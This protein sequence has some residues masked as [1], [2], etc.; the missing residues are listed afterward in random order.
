MHSQWAPA[1]YLPPHPVHP[2]FLAFQ[3]YLNRIAPTADPSPPR[4]K[5]TNELQTLISIAI[6]ALAP[7][8]FPV[9][10]VSVP[11]GPFCILC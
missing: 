6:S 11:P 9:R 7:F 4:K 8:L 5:T 3:L 1:F 2:V 10:I